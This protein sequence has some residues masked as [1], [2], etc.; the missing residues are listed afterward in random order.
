MAAYDLEEQEQLSAIKAWW[1]K[2]GNLLTYAALAVAIV[3]LG[4]VSW[5]RY[6]NSRAAQASALLGEVSMALDHGDKQAA[7][8]ASGRLF[9]DY[10]GTLQADLG[11]LLMARA[12]SDAK[13]SK[14]A[15]PKL[16]QIIDKASD[17]ALRDIARLRLAALQLDDGAY[18]DAL[19]TLE[20]KPNDAFA[21]RFADLRGDILFAKGATEQARA[22]YA[23]ASGLLAKQN[24][25]STL[26]SAVDVK[27]EA[28]GG[29]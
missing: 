16:Q 18:D 25:S 5:G 24:G 6:Q 12:E 21:A 7:Q 22:A 8:Q 20:A 9:A 26:K 3:V 10:S 23:E 28:L 14:S 27:L 29:A 17:S 1:E 11:A 2:H 4:W 15:K 19:K 13:D